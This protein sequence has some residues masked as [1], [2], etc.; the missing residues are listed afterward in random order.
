MRHPLARPVALALGALLVAVTPTRAHAQFGALTRRVKEK[1]EQVAGDRSHGADSAASAAA[2]R[3]LPNAVTSANASRSS[4]EVA[5]D[6]DVLAR[7]LRA[8]DAEREQAHLRQRAAAPARADTPREGA[9]E[10]DR[11]ATCLRQKVNG[12]DTAESRKK[13]CGTLDDAVAAEHARL[14][15]EQAGAHARDSLRVLAAV[16]PDSAGAAAGGFGTR[17]YGI[18]KERVTA[19]LVLAANGSKAECMRNERLQYRYTSAETAALTARRPALEQ[20]FLDEQQVRDA[21]VG[22][23]RRA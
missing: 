17:Q 15:R 7:M 20:R 13:K 11:Y 16:S 14:A 21:I 23:C 4:S 9:D 22:R 18:L 6:D 2:G 3:R 19:F 12:F 10:M 1:V 5:L 8:A